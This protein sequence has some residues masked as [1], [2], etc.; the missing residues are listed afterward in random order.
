MSRWARALDTPKPESLKPAYTSPS[1]NTSTLHPAPYAIDAM[2]LS[3]QRTSFTSMSGRVECQGASPAAHAADLGLDREAMKDALIIASSA[4]QDEEPGWTLGNWHFSE[5]DVSLT[6]TGETHTICVDIGCTKSVIDRD[7]L[8][9]H[10]DPN[11]HVKQCRTHNTEEH[12]R[13]LHGLS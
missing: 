12:M 13:S 6:Q 10:G 4:E 5:V 7:F 2:T 8:N 11:T 1:P 3:H 9:T